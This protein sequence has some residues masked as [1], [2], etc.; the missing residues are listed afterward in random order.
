MQP[1]TVQDIGGGEGAA[2]F[3]VL[4]LEST[5]KSSTAA[6]AL[7]TAMTATSQQCTEEADVHY[8]GR[9]GRI[10][11]FC[12]RHKE[13]VVVLEQAVQCQHGECDGTPRYGGHDGPLTFCRAH[14]RAGMYTTR[15]G[16]LYV[17]TRDGSAFRKDPGPPRATVN[18][19]RE[20]ATAA[21]D[22]AA[23]TT[24]GP[25]T[26]TP[27]TP[28]RGPKTDA[29]QTAA[30]TVLSPSQAA[31]EVNTPPP[32]SKK[33][34]TLH[35]KLC[36][37]PGC[38]VQPSFGAPG[39]GKPRF[40][41]GH[42]QEGHVSLKN[43]PCIFPGCN[44][45]PHYGPSM[46]R[47]VFCATHKKKSHVHLLKEAESLGKLQELDTQRR[48]KLLKS[49]CKKER[50]ADAKRPNKKAKRE[51][52]GDVSPEVEGKGQKTKK[53]KDKSD[54]GVPQREGADESPRAAD[55]GGG[56]SGG[57]RARAPSRKFLE[58]SGRVADEGAQL[59]TKAKKEEEN[60]LKREMKEQRRAAKSAGLKL[61]EVIEA[62]TVPLCEEEEPGS[63]GGGGGGGGGSRGSDGGG[64][65]FSVG[66]A[67]P[68]WRKLSLSGM[69]RAAQ[70][71][72]QEE[73]QPAEAEAKQRSLSTKD[74]G[75]KS[76]AV[77][78]AGKKRERPSAPAAAPEN[79]GSKPPKGDGGEPTG[80]PSQRRG[81]TSSS[82]GR[83]D[84]G[85]SSKRLRLSNGSGGGG[86]S[87]G[88]KGHDSEGKRRS[89]RGHEGE[90]ESGGKTGGG[91]VNG[92]VLCEIDTCYR[93]ASY[94]IGDTARLCRT[95]S[96][97]VS[98]L[99]RLSQKGSI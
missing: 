42:K 16:V 20:G 46:G 86:G 11:R 26:A 22:A 76:G 82:S 53:K 15:D 30:P 55:D 50:S 8:M 72:Q 29:K 63:G 1:C 98:W 19:D 99:W 81:K 45:R 35:R 38:N 83:T 57:R 49:T 12:T 37:V 96:F 64:D 13:P 40:C 48:R 34:Q 54:K 78:T 94:G 39:T 89:P 32:G 24:G 36:E 61:G 2:I 59:L 5:A 73:Q 41:T 31:E 87:R 95:V 33:G 25:E 92:K 67:S 14:K 71:Q 9:D 51:T 43:R 88:G 60:R 4:A 70:Q 6:N 52:K 23:I 93:P 44:T 80:T 3:F 77:P 84:N 28:S 65:A 68:S 75:T 27:A 21:A 7:R 62:T 69:L 10:H 47:P 18:G 90:G 66:E 56:G 17:A 58:A 85:K 97:I 74:S 91:T 79:G